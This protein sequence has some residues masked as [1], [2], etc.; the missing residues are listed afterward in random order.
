MKF[1]TL[2]AVIATLISIGGCSN[3]NVEYK[4]LVDEEKV[5][6]KLVARIGDCGPE[7]WREITAVKDDG[8]KSLFIDQYSYGESPDGNLDYIL[9]KNSE[10]K[11][12]YVNGSWKFECGIWGNRR[13]IKPSE[14]KEFKKYLTE[15]D[16][17]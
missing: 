7:Y 4:G 15:T 3:V 9:R 17:I 1:K 11:T 5:T 12:T 2:C 16:G 13:E 8:S 10:G 6:R 14:Q